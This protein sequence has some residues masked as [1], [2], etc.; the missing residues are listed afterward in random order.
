[1]ERVFTENIKSYV[2]STGKAVE[3]TDLEPWLRL[4]FGIDVEK[5][6]EIV[7]INKGKIIINP[8]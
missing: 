5:G 6:S 1:M 3:L 2:I 4:F 7:K 8:K